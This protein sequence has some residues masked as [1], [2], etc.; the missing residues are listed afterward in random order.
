MKRILVTG[1][2]GFI[3]SHVVDVLLVSGY[4]VVV[5]L[6]P[7]RLRKFAPYEDCMVSLG[8]S[9]SNATRRKSLC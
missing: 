1:G 8:L 2:A 4:R 7:Y 9:L 3:G 5:H 6:A